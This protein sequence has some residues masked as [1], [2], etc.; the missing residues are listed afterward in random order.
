MEQ[1]LT[2]KEAAAFLGGDIT[3]GTLKRWRYER[4]GPPHI[5]MGRHVRYSPSDLREW[6]QRQRV[7][8]AGAHGAR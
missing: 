4:K 6:V 7:V 1:L 5:P 2:P 8:P 3:P